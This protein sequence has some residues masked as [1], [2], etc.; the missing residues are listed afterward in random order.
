MS[1]TKTKVSPEKKKEKKKSQWGDVWRRLRRNRLAMLGLFLVALMVFSSLFASVIAPYDPAEMTPERMAGISAKHIMGTDNYGRDTFS[2]VL[3][4]GRISLLVSVMS[5]LIAVVVG[6]LLGTTA[7]YFGGLY[8]TIVMRVTDILMAVPAFLMALLVSVALG[9]GPVNTAI[10]I[11]CS[12]I[13]AYA[14]VTRATVLTTKGEQYVEAAKSYGVGKMRIILKQILPNISSPILVQS[15]LRIGAGIIA[16]SG[17]SF[18]NL[19]VRPPTAE[20]G[21]MMSSSIVY[22]R[23]NPLLVIF[24]G[25]AIILTI[26]GFNLF[27]DGLRDALDPKLKR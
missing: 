26:F 14:R 20:W 8:E 10:A 24:P 23:V 9:S 16:I 6:G 13:P 7:G 5:V 21:S 15:T 1:K 11:A 18:I 2:R 19:G 25:L 3:Y 27:G 4:G 17:L 12:A 22:F